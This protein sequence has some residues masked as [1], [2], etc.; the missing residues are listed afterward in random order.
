[1]VFLLLAACSSAT[2]DTAT[3]APAT[4]TPKT[5]PTA[6]PTS[7]PASP[8]PKVYC[9]GQSPSIEDVARSY[10][11]PKYGT[12]VEILWQSGFVPWWVRA[13]ADGR[14]LAV[15]DGGDSIYE[16][17]PDG[18]LAVA[19]ACP[20][21]MIETFAAASDGALWFV[22]RRGGALFRVDPSGEVT[23]IADNGNRNLEAGPDGSVYAL[24]KGLYQYTPDGQR[25]TISTE[26]FG[27]K[28][29]V[30]PN[31]ELAFNLGGDI[32][33]LDEGGELQI[34]ASG[35]G[36][37]PWPTF[38]ADGLLYVTHWTNVTVFDLQTG[39][40]HTLPFL[41]DAG[42]GESGAFA[43]DG[44]LLLYHP[45]TNVYAV[46]LQTEEVT[47]YHNT[48]SNS[49]AM[50]VNPGDATYIAFGDQRPGGT[51]AIYRITGVHDLEWVADIDFGIERSMAFDSQGFGY[52][53]AADQQNGA[54]I[55]RFDPA[56]G[57]TERYATA[58]CY[59]FSITVDPTTD[60][61]WWVDCNLVVHLNEAGQR[62][63]IDKPAKTRN[64][65]IAITPGGD[66]Y[67][68]AWH[69]VSD[70]GQ[71]GQH[72][73]LKWNPD[74]ETWDFVVD[75]TQ[76]DP[77]ITLATLV[78]CPDNHIYTVEGLSADN[79]PVNYSS[80][81]SVRRLEDDNTLTLLGYNLSFDGLAADCDPATNRIVF[82]SG[83]GIFALTPPED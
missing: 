34:L 2:A 51:T 60:Q 38:A 49:W 44:R 45:N 15:S 3:T 77:G 12:Q 76:S 68:V 23:R 81:N 39:E 83:A 21:A 35:F 26:V 36:P 22:E 37:E 63:S 5:E 27:R 69:P 8:T 55:T 13:S 75:M 32:A 50:A 74:T 25:T 71:P 17:K 59:P 62:V 7:I 6:R 20:G 9:Q 33:T 14:I 30:G 66:L 72:E 70:P 65:S 61:P 40:S 11:Q 19:F 28:M 79:L 48:I 78:A 67:A 24:E 4:T 16:L 29:A 73:I 53:A 58:D 52:I 1:M 56:T 54:A 31:G 41:K 42:L 82:T 57:E 43:P 46:D 47:T 80:Y 18:T 10:A 64:V